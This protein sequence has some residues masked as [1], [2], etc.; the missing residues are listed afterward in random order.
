MPSFKVGL[1]PFFTSD[2]PNDQVAAADRKVEEFRNAIQN[3][4]PGMTIFEH[5]RTTKGGHKD[6][7]T[8]AGAELSKAMRKQVQI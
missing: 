3:Y 5:K 4:R 2:D 8:I 1:H 7:K 6:E